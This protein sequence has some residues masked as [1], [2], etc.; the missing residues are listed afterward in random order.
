MLLAFESSTLSPRRP[1]R[2][3]WA[4]SGGRWLQR[5]AGEGVLELADALLQAGDLLPEPITLGREF[6]NTFRYLGDVV[7]PTECFAA[8]ALD[9]TVGAHPLSV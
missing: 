5:V 2:C 6:D 9:G 4:G 1:E 8:L 7:M 3:G